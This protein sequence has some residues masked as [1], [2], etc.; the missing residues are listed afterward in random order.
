MK[1]FIIFWLCIQNPYTTLEET[2][3]DQIMY[4][5]AYDTREECRE[6]SARLANSFME[7]P[8]VYVTTFCTTKHTSEI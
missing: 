1:M 8:N 5:R 2:C 7:Q 6:A 4:D 3:V